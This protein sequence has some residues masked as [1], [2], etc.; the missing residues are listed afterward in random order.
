MPLALEN[1]LDVKH[2]EKSI[3][4]IL[5]LSPEALK[6]VSNSDA[7]KLKEAFGITTIRQ[8][9]ENK[10]FMAAAALARAG[11][12][13]DYDPGPPPFWLNKFAQLP[14]SY[15]VN[16][17]SGRF[18]VHFGGV[19]YRG[20]LDDT[21]RVIVVGQDPSTDEAI[22]RRAF[23]GNAGQRLQKLLYKT[24]IVRS[25]IIINTFAYSII[26]QANNEMRIIAQE[27]I[28]KNFREDLLNTLIERN[29]IEAIITLGVGAK[30]AMSTW[31]NPE[32]K[33]MFHLF[34]PSAQTGLEDNW[35]THLPLL[36]AN[37]T[38]DNPAI[39]DA[40]P[41]SGEWSENTHRMN[42]PRFDLPYNLPDWHGTEG[43][44]SNRGPDKIKEIT[45]TSIL[46]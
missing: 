10:F 37:I 46:S 27:P 9:G 3:V 31:N 28:I 39:I 21:A 15:Y 2:R 35:N 7:Q 41:Y 42:I 44:N 23:V 30:E 38:P 43:T 33:Q 40:T 45:W 16:H 6:G 22:A 12:N 4:E 5:E 25:Y 20:R 1:L 19:P 34:H 18:R 17:P 14:D 24:G 26:G 36:I 11:M 32:N 29:P 13:P 8:L